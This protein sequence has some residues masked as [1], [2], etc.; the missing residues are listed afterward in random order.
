MLFYKY[1]KNNSKNLPEKKS[2]PEKHLNKHI[3]YLLDSI[4]SYFY[5]PDWTMTRKSA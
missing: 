1:R 2:F 5:V 3:D 4:I